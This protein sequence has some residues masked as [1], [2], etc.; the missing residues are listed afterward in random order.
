[1]KARFCSI[2]SFQ[3]LCLCLLVSVSAGAQQSDPSLKQ[4]EQWLKQY[5]KADTN[6]DGKLSAEELRALRAKLGKGKNKAVHAARKPTFADV[7]YGPH[8]RNTLNFWK[9]DTQAPAPLAV[10]IHGGGFI[11]GD[12]AQV[13]AGHMESLLKAGI[14]VASINYRYSTQAP[15]PAPMLD[16]ARAIQFLRSKAEEW[17]IDAKRVA[18]FGGSAGAGISMWLAFHDDLAK[19]DSSDPVERQ[20]TRLTC[21]G[22]MGGQPSYNP[23]VIREWIGGRAWEH[24][25]LVKLF[26]LNST[27]DFEKPEM[28]AIMDD[29]SAITHLTRDD[30]PVVMLYGEPDEPLPA[31]CKPGQG[32]H[33]PK[34]GH[35]LKEKMDALGIECVYRHS[36]DGAQPPASQAFVRFLRDHLLAKPQN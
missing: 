31:D 4:L 6:G 36:A 15:Y 9:A 18:A 20:S 22:S 7:K 30:P 17:N 29:A 21:A 10:H 19:P 11:S 28:K 34:F 26:G 2:H 24:P 1:M 16:S 23:L 3:V 14:S 25:A 35:I 8:E 12:K 13:T 33:H 5:P 32:I 27:R